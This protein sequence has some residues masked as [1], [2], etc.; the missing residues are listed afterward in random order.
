MKKILFL[1]IGFHFF[2]MC[3]AQKKIPFSTEKSIFYSSENGGSANPSFSILKSQ[4]ELD[5]IL[6]NQILSMEESEKSPIKFIE[7]QKV[8]LY[9]LGEFRSGSHLPGRILYFKLKNETLEIYIPKKE[10]LNEDKG[11]GFEIQV[12][13]RPFIIFSIPKNIDFENISLK[14]E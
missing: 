8:I 6:G 14:Y 2:T 13:T 9:N 7:N 1:F 12:I 11:L 3:S 5:K 10:F 4:K